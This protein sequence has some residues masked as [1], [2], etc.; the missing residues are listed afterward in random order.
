MQPPLNA[1]T[2]HK[3]ILTDMKNGIAKMIGKEVSKIQKEATKQIHQLST[4]I[5]TAINT[6]ISKVLQTIH[7]LNQCFNEVMEHLPLTQQQ[8]PAQK[9]SKGH[10]CV[11][12]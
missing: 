2:L 1:T 11:F 9:K 5:T 10:K 12:M 3:Q 8:I 7:A 6:Q 4:M